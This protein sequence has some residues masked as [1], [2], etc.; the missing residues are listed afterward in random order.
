MCKEIN[1]GKNNISNS[2]FTKYEDVKER[3][4]KATEKYLDLTFKTETEKELK[5]K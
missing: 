5:K 1:M 2:A 4:N 3:L